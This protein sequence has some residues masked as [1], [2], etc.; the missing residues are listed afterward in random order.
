MQDY[1]K[2]CLEAAIE[3]AVSARE[4]GN[5]PFGAVLADAS[6]K[7]LLWAENTVVTSRDITAHAELNLIREAASNYEAEFLAACTLYSSTEPCPMCA[8]GIFWS[9]IR[10]VVYGLS[11]EGLYKLT[12]K[13]TE[14]VLLLSCRE[15]FAQG[16]KT[17]R[18]VGP[19]L[20]EKAREPH[21]GFWETIS[22]N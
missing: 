1:D 15:V 19:M 20:E 3:A 6:G 9:N 18:V 11:E 5:H 14:E 7:I 17:I 21:L 2:K 16:K 12:G 13:D 4:H 22:E 8:G 10:R